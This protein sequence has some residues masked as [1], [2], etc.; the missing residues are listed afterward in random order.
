MRML[1]YSQLITAVIIM[2]VM[3]S[4]AFA[5]EQQIAQ[6]SHNTPLANPVS[7]E[8]DLELIA[9]DDYV[10]GAVMGTILGFGSGHAMQG[11]WD[12]GGS[13]FAAWE[14]GFLGGAGLSAFGFLHTFDL[15]SNRGDVFAGLF[16]AAG[17][18]FLVTRVF[19]IVDLWSVDHQADSE[20]PAT[21]YAP[22]IGYNSDNDEVSFGLALT[23]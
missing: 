9:F 10:D 22:A 12:D 21:T 18:G 8:L 14:A 11:R 13:A 2:N 3:T 17:V 19:E 5:S 16:V 15:Y 20:E 6:S 1:K 7:H 4:A 23:F